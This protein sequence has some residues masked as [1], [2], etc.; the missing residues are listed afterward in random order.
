MIYH[1][2][3]YLDTL[4]DIPGSFM[5]RSITFRAGAAAVSALVIAFWPEA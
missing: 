5:F 4:I 2:I 3:R 1:L